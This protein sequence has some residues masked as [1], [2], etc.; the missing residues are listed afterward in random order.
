MSKAAIGEIAIGVGVAALGVFSGGLGLVLSPAIISFLVGTGASLVLG[1]LGSIFSS[2]GSSGGISSASRNPIAPFNVVYGRAKVGGSI[3]YLEETGDSNK[4][5]HMVIVL[6]CHPSLA[7]DALLFDN[8]AV[9]M[10]TGGSSVD[11]TVSYVG[12][13]S[14]TPTQATVS[15]TSITRV[16]DVVTVVLDSSL[17][18]VDGETLDIHD[19]SDN[20][21]NGQFPVTRISDSSFTYICGGN[22]SSSTSGS[23]TTM[24]PDWSNKA[25]M[26]VLLGDHTKTFPGLKSASNGRWTARHMLLGRTAVYLRLSYDETVFANGLPGIS[27]M[28]RG[29]KDILD[30]RTGEKGYTENA[31]LCTADYLAHPTWGFRAI[32]GTEIPTDQLTAAANICDEDLPTAG[33]STE[34]RYT[35]NGT[36]AL[37][38]KRGEILQNLLTACGGRLTY[39]GGQYVIRPAAWPGTSLAIGDDTNVGITNMMMNGDGLVVNAYNAV[40][41]RGAYF[42]QSAGTSEGQFLM[43]LGLLDAAAAT[44]SAAALEMGKLTLSHVLQV[45]YRGQPIPAEVDRGGNNFAP[46]WLF[47]VKSAFRDAVIDYSKTFTF[48]SGAATIPDLPGAPVHYVFQVCTTDYKLLWDNPY[49]VLTAGDSYPFT[50]AYDETTK[51]TTVTLTGA[52]SSFSGS[53]VVIHSTKSGDFIRPGQVFE[54]WPDWRPLADGEIDSA[55]DV[56][57]WAYRAFTKASDVIGAPW[58]DTARATKEQTAIAYDVGDSRDWVRPS[59][60]K[61]PFSDGARFQFH[62]T[63][64][65]GYY[66]PWDEQ[67]TSLPE[68][69]FSGDDA[70]NV[71]LSIGDESNTVQNPIILAG[72]NAP[73][74]AHDHETDGSFDGYQYGNASVG[75]TYNSGDST[76]IV[77]GFL[78]YRNSQPEWMGN[79]YWASLVEVAA[80]RVQCYIDTADQTTLTR[81]SDSAQLHS[82]WTRRTLHSFIRPLARLTYKTS[83]STLL[84]AHLMETEHSRLLSPVPTS[85]TLSVTPFQ[86]VQM[87]IPSA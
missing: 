53:L 40:E 25:Y 50:T 69:G 35:V 34:P 18:V 65:S 16:N 82:W 56:F 66:D 62:S 14:Y 10:Q 57:N 74:G 58:N 37:S 78:Q 47:N 38:T 8:Q 72:Y 3:V 63:D 12:R 6:A 75:D 80:A 36:F 79:V 77:L 9:P 42:P 33:G 45:L 24:Y 1:G 31:A 48:T 61:N 51:V 59:Y 76:T 70:G 67:F 64:G 41:G 39:S 13:Q 7:V 21:M 5:L 60:T 44:G 68:P 22:A 46:H 71:I 84:P 55:S 73:G 43:A 30:V 15:I 2:S 17:P 27:F 29:K 52:H 81:P 54:A 11:P 49:S 4:E 85:K 87:F 83:R 32:Y 23:V 20:T 28:V 19:V 26:E 86:L